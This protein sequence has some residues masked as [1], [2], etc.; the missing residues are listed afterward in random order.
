[1][2]AMRPRE[3][4]AIENAPRTVRLLG[5]QQILEAALDGAVRGLG[6]L[7]CIDCLRVFRACIGFGFTLGTCRRDACQA[8]DDAE[9]GSREAHEGRSG[10]HL[11]TL[12]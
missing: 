5:G 12:S 8:D 4:P 7:R 6:Q 9:C 2:K 1:M 3:V 10:F 11:A